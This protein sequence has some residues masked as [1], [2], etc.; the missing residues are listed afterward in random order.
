MHRDHIAPDG[1]IGMRR[2]LCGDTFAAELH[3]RGFTPDDA[4]EAVGLMYG[5]SLG[6]ARLFIRSHPARAGEGPGCREAG[7]W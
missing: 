7:R 2:G 1:L 5:V 4:A 6:A 3:D